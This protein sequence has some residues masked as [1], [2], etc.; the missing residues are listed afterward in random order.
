MKVGIIGGGPVGTTCACLIKLTCPNVQVHIFEQR[1]AFNRD[2]IIL[3]S[4]HTLSLYPET[5]YNC[6]IKQGCF[7]D[8]PRQD[9]TGKCYREQNN[10]E[11]LEFSIRISILEEMLWELA[12]S[13]KVKTHRPKH[14][15]SSLTM[16]SPKLKQFDILIGAGGKNDIVR[17]WLD[18]PIKEKH[19]SDA[20]IL[21]WDPNENVTYK[22]DSR[23]K[24]RRSSSSQDRFR[25]FR[26][27]HT[28][29]YAS[30][31]VSKSEA[32]KLESINPTGHLEDITDPDILATFR[33]LFDYYNI[34]DNE[35][36]GKGKIS[37]VPISL[38]TATDFVALARLPGSRIST[39][40]ILMIVI[41]DAV[42][43]VHFYSGTGVNTGIKMAHL[44][45][46][47]ICDLDNETISHKQAMS[48]I[49]KH[50]KEYIRES[51][52]RSMTVTLKA[53]TLGKCNAHTLK[54]LR[55]LAKQKNYQG[56]S[57]LSKT[58]MCMIMSSQV[59]F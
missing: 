44:T 41:G 45:A 30:I 37:L 49:R 54:E 56:I 40:D 24:N 9:T 34:S 52:E 4:K 59:T 32:K 12:R 20:I 43:G 51:K 11:S 16:D 17:E 31:Q 29:Y 25:A 33:N 1:S 58:D 22:R 8:P 50:F 19:I 3:L 26:S 36:G 57:N 35:V 23:K 42:N 39:Q 13:L 48:N 21:T 2:Q 10:E 6:L 55:M 18:I 28:N 7:I 5:F 27:P 15:R 14:G 47:T 38:Y 46:E 53:G